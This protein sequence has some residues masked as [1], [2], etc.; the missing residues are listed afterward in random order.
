MRPLTYLYGRIPLHRHEHI[1]ILY[2]GREE[3]FSAASF[4]AEGLKHNNL[5]VYLA[6]DDYQAEML[7][8]LRGLPL[9]VDCHAR[10]GC[11]GCIMVGHPSV[12]SAMDESNL[13]RRG[14][15]RRPL[16]AM[17]GRGLWT[18]DRIFPCRNS[19]S[20]MPFSTTG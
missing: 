12:A 18:A 20:F 5:C 4:L 13:R 14:A 10:D 11:C 3:A 7:S 19:S 17:A 6:P 15:C 9:D 1:A 2:R 8:R 16:P